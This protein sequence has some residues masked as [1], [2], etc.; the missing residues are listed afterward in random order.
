M[1]ILIADD[2]PLVRDALVRALAAFDASVSFGEAADHDSLLALAD[3]SAFDVALVDLG[4][5]G[6]DGLAS[7]RRLRARQPTLPVIVVSGRAE[8]GTVRAVLEAGANGF[9]PKTEPADILLQALRTVVGGGVYLPPHAVHTLHVD[10]PEASA[11][12]KAAPVL[13]PRQRDVLTLL[14]QG[15]PNKTI[16]RELG[17]SEGTVKLHIAA[18]LRALRASNRTEATVRARALGLDAVL[19]PPSD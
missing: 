11:A 18:L 19:P 9:V 5:P 16:A 14:L 8:P 6:A 3:S 13:T 4:M 12:N 15:A 7:L 1:K 2:H 10:A 17:L